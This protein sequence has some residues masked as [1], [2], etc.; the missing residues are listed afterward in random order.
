MVNFFFFFFF[1]TKLDEKSIAIKKY[2]RLSTHSV[3]NI[4]YYTNAKSSRCGDLYVFNGLKYL[5]LY[6][7]DDFAIVYRLCV[8]SI[9][10]FKY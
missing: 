10:D 7:H 3:V 5:F 4:V 6:T 9:Y 2:V 8:Q 1:L